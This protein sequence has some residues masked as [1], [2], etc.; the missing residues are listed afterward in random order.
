VRFGINVVIVDNRPDRTITGRADT[1][2]PKTIETLKQMRLADQLLQKGV[3]VH[4]MR[5]WSSTPDQTLRRLH[6]D[7]QFPPD[8]VD[9]ID[10]Y[11]LNAH[12]GILEDTF[13]RDMAERGLEV[14]RNL[15]FVDYH[16]TPEDASIR[17]VCEA[18][19]TSDRVTFH[20]RYLVG[21]DGAHSNVRRTMGSR[22]VGNANGEI[23]GVIDGVLETN[24]PDAYSK[25]VVHSA[26]NGTLV[27]LPRERD[28]TRIYVE[29]KTD[30]GDK[31]SKLELSQEYVMQRA[32]EIL[33]PY[34]L[35]W[36]SI[37]WFGRYQIGRKIAS[38]F[39]DDGGASRVFITGDAAHTFSPKSQGMNDSMHDSWN[40]AWKL[41]LAIR[42][43]AKPALLASYEDERRQVAED[44]VDYD[45][46]HLDALVTGSADDFAENH[47]RNA[48]II[49]GFGADYAP[50]PVVVPQRGSL[51][52]A[53]RVGSTLPPAKVTRFVDVNPVDIQ[54]DMPMLGA[55]PSS[56]SV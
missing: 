25:C 12:Q 45:H 33:E 13:L 8:L 21:C 9:T 6:R 41:N 17:V 31:A 55:P 47:L 40:L 50:S 18:A 29:L 15:T 2:Q 27:M 51:L 43:L 28:M 38:R 52:G 26:E 3:K 1:L 37:E 56:P 23:W 54:L 48:R 44:L 39:Q 34:N 42:G 35:Q 32:T 24:F 14:H 11:Q 46:E 30:I 16:T 7:V 19:H 36:A 10:P 5:L 4:D 22:L 53:L 49:S 20:S